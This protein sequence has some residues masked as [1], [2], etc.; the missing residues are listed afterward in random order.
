MQDYL[1]ACKAV[2]THGV[3]GELKVELWCDSAAFLAGFSRLYRGPQGQGPI[4][5]VKVR[6]HK[7][8]ALLTLEGVHDPGTA[9]GLV[10]TVFY[11]ARA[12][13]KLPKGHYFQADLIG[14]PVVDAG[15]GRVYG[16]IETVSHPA[17][18]DIYTVRC[19]DGSQ[20]LFPAVKPFLK[21][22]DIPGG[23][24]LVEPIPGMFGPAESG[25]EP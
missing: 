20:A 10:G 18:Q 15:S 6:P 16:V 12:E 4:G 2:T 22:V 9:R 14:L 11:I 5:L 25:D 23:R 24:V 7:N 3:A 1:E 21:Q 8:M 13:A 17:A 19:P